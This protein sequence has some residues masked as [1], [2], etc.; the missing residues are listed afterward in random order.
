VFLTT[1]STQEQNRPE[2][3]VAAQHDQIDHAEFFQY[4]DTEMSS[5]AAA[6]N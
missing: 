4:I 6:N 2:W 1:R 3:I 5:V